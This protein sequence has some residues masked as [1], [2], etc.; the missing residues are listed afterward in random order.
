MTGRTTRKSSA[1]T[2][3]K[4]ASKAGKA[5]KPTAKPAAAKTDAKVSAPLASVTPPPSVAPPA[6]VAK[7]STSHVPAP[8]A[9]KIASPVKP[10]VAS[11]VQPTETTQITAGDGGPQLKKQELF[12]KTAD[13]SG[14]KK[15]QVKP[16]IEA[17]L[18]VIGE[19]LAQGREINLPPLGK[20]K[21]NRVKDSAGARIIIAKIR[22]AKPNE[23]DDKETV[24][25]D[26]E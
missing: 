9:A 26:A 10:P 12:K 22:Q 3:R 21:Q 19:A 4:S 17:A 23:K 14:I 24:A 16:A 1:K 6:A 7:P 15:N 2:A 5:A 8:P 25:D 18:E 13:R 20:I 11:V